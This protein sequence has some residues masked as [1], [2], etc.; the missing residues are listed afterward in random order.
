MGPSLPLVR[1]PVRTRDCVLSSVDGVICSSPSILLS[2]I[3][4]QPDYTVF[5]DHLGIPCTDVSFR[6]SYGVYHS[7]YDSFTWME[8]WGDK[9]FTYHE[10]MAQIWGLMT[11]RLADS[12]V[13]PFNY[14]DYGVALSEYAHYMETLLSTHGGSGKGAQCT[15]DES[16]QQLMISP[17]DPQSI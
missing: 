8:L 4:M 13:L 3:H 17:C 6:G 12:A 5:L 2:A 11:L 9:N 15:A 1:D 10:A 14:T 16:L 7:I